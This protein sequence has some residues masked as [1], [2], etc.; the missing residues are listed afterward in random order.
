MNRPQRPSYCFSEKANAIFKEWRLW[1]STLK[2]FNDPFGVQDVRR[3]LSF[4]PK[5]CYILL[6]DYSH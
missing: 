5:G 4:L 6:H 2:E 1:F 3:R